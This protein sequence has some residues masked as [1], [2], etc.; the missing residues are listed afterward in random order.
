MFQNKQRIKIQLCRES[1]CQNTTQRFGYR[2]N[3]LSASEFK[4]E[5][6]AVEM[7]HVS[8]YWQANMVPFAN[9]LA[10]SAIHVLSGFLSLFLFAIIGSSL[11]AVYT[12]FSG[13]ITVTW[14]QP[15]RKWNT[16]PIQMCYFWALPQYC[17]RRNTSSDLFSRALQDWW[18]FWA[19]HID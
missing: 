18:T 10:P 16:L 19:K 2:G 13:C 11:L 12:F 3:N 6:S 4:L 9:H 14:D 15:L 7:V 17:R 1:A 8:T 5:P